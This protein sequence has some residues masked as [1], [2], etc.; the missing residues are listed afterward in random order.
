MGKI[1]VAGLAN[2]ESSVNIGE[3]PV[4]YDPMFNSKISVSS[5]ASGSGLN[6]AKALA[7]LGDEVEFLSLTGDDVMGKAVEN[8]LEENNISTEYILPILNETPQSVVL[9]EQSGKRQIYGDLKDVQD[10]Y[11]DQ[12]LFG[13]ALQ[14]C[15]AVVLSNRNFVRP[16]LKPAREKG[17]TVAVNVHALSDVYDS[18]NEEYMRSADILFFSGDAIA[19][20]AFDFVKALEVEYKNEIIMVGLGE[21]GALLYSKK[22]EFIGQFP[23]VRTRKIVNTAGAGDALFSAFLHSYFKTKDPY[24]SIKNALLFASYKIG[25]E[26]ASKGFLTEEQL[27][28]FYPIIWK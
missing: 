6:M 9:Y 24:Y 7:V 17:K 26:N 8:W 5:A 15:E 14:E 22:D 28:K 1:V 18:Y 10:V 25:T 23:S 27:E 16:F 3:F 13:K 4:Q 11:Y 2:I 19:G 12:E 20:S 21:K